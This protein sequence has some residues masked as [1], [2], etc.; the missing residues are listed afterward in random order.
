MQLIPSLF[1]SE[2]TTTQ[3]PPIAT[4][5]QAPT[6]GTRNPPPTQQ[7]RP[8]VAKTQSQASRMAYP[9]PAEAKARQQR[10][11]AEKK[12]SLTPATKEHPVVAK[13]QSQASRIGQPLPPPPPGFRYVTAEEAEVIRMNI[14]GVN[15]AQER[16]KEIQL[17]KI[18][19]N[20][21]KLVHT[22]DALASIR[23]KE[24][25]LNKDFEMHQWYFNEL[26]SLKIVCQQEERELE[27][28]VKKFEQELELMR[29]KGISPKATPIRD[30]IRD[31][32]LRLRALGDMITVDLEL[33][34]IIDDLYAP[35]VQLNGRAEAL[36][37]AGK[38]LEHIQ[39]MFN[40][41]IIEINALGD[42][43]GDLHKKIEAFNIEEIKAQV[44]RL[45]SNCKQ[46][47][48]VLNQEIES[49]ETI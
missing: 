24:Q 23:C 2:K 34:E 46:S 13:T 26:A 21:E 36:V 32:V 17:Q 5:S 48:L 37:A 41:S 43:R 4:Q 31:I 27:L 14:Q 33:V 22:R 12:T 15:E 8:I 18:E 29:T 39:A 10:S 44:D 28:L 35:I 42:L 20:K 40:A 47:T 1:R 49:L 38:N 7:N 19:I 25:R 3:N 9:S 45:V 6:I 30:S 11:V 16:L